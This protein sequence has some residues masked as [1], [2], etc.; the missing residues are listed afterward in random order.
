MDI[1]RKQI[2]ETF[3]RIIAHVSDK[4]YQKRVWVEGKGP[5]WDDFDETVCL[6]FHE[7]D[8]ILEKHKDFGI[9]ESQ[10]KLLVKLRSA[11]KAFSDDNDYPEEFIEST[12]WKKIMEIAKEVLKAFN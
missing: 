8:S 12:E 6:F 10:Y 9:T 11:F 1:D 3:I 7:G 2:L 5:E 4:E